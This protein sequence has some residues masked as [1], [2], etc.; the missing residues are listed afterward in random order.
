MSPNTCAMSLLTKH[1]LEKVSYFFQRLKKNIFIVI[2]F[3]IEISAGV[4]KMQKINV[5]DQME[6][7]DLGLAGEIEVLKKPCV[8]WIDFKLIILLFT[9]FHKIS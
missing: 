9:L 3:F 1:L 4:N 8:F 7:P 5:Q 2:L 6:F